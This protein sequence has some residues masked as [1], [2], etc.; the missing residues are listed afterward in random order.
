[1]IPKANDNGE[2][3]ILFWQ[4]ESNNLAVVLFFRSIQTCLMFGYI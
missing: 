1:M 3:E 2:Y 4:C